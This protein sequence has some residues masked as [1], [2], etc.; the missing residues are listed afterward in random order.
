MELQAQRGLA[1][2]VLPIP[3]ERRLHIE[4]GETDEDA[5]Y[6]AQTILAAELRLS[7]AWQDEHLSYE[8][9]RRSRAA[10]SPISRGN[11]SLTV[12]VHQKQW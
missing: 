2:G 1:L 6:V 7:E 12:V 10:W 5:V 11:R 9:C 3:V 8:G 4:D